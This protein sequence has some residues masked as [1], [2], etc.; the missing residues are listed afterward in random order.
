[1]RSHTTDRD[2]QTVRCLSRLT[3][4]QI[5]SVVGVNSE[6]FGRCRAD[7][8]VVVKTTIL[9]RGTHVQCAIERAQ[10]HGNLIQAT[11]PTPERDHFLPIEGRTAVTIGFPDLESLVDVHSARIKMSFHRSHLK[12]RNVVWI[13]KTWLANGYP[14]SPGGILA[15]Q[16]DHMSS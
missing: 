8:I 13:A 7:I 9:D 14:R 2:L 3:N 6:D 1:T 16:Q 15:R 10:R 11:P 12:D 4:N 5:P